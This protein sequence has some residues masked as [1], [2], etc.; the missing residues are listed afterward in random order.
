M[1]QSATPALSGRDPR[2]DILFQPMKIGPVTAKNRF[3]QV[4]HCTG[5]GYLRPHMLSEM[6]RVK[7]EGGWGVIC[8]EYTSIHPSSDDL[9]HVSASL[10][11]SD[12]ISHMQLMTDAL[13]ENGA[14]AG[15]E[16]WYGG[17]R[18]ANHFTRLTA[19]DVVDLPNLQGHPMQAR[20]MDRTDIRDLRRWHKKAALRARDAGFDIVYVYATHGYA[21]ANF[22]DPR[23]NTRGDEYGGSLE[24]RVRL[25]RELIEDTKEAVGDRCA[26]AVRFKADDTIGQDGVPETGE[27]RE[28]F[29]M[30]AELPD[31][32]DINIADYSLEMG[33]AR[34]VA[35]GALEVGLCKFFSL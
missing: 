17:A 33:A 27:R 1:T 20:A 18:S 14:L 25:V 7:A 9:T 22:L 4:P 16:L 34:F 8:T 10:W 2:H 32:W 26:V 21:L 19:M 3:Y 23:V 6:R 24:N 28:M 12:D 5:M 29:E 35:E 11:N 15:A 30:L 13:H 31:L